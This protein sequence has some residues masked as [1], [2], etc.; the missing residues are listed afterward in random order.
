MGQLEHDILE[1]ADAYKNPDEFFNAIET[2]II[3]QSSE[4]SGNTFNTIG[5]ILFNASYFELALNSW[6][7]ALKYFT[8]IDNKAGISGIYINMANTYISQDDFIKAYE[9]F[10]RALTI[11]Q[12]TKNKAILELRCYA[13]FGIISN[14]QGEYRKAIGYN[15]R[16][17]KIAETIGDKPAEAGLCRNLGDNFLNLGNF[18]QAIEFYQR[19]LTIEQA[20]GN[21]LG[22]SL[23]YA[24]L[25]TVCVNSGKYKTA[26]DH[27]EKALALISDNEGKDSKVIESTCYSGLGNAFGHLGEYRREIEYYE[28]VL[29]IA[30]DIADRALELR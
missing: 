7:N 22:Q 14:S 5:N 24:N 8:V 12:M 18:L 23:S 29:K 21:N 4:D 26:I 1:L 11:A 25:G 17:L 10:E 27:Y 19:S 2:K 15:E 3:G 6:N 13:G 20:N 16:A 9:Y 30:Y 28:K